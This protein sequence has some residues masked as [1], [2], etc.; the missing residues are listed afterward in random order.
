MP[1]DFFVTNLVLFGVITAAATFGQSYLKQKRGGAGAGNDAGGSPAPAAMTP[2]QSGSTR[3]L[4]RAYILVYALV[5]GADWLQGPYM[6][7]LYSTHYEFADRTVA[8]LFVF[9]FTAGGISAPY[10]GKWADKHGR[11]RMCLVFCATYGTSCLI[12]L[13]RSLPLLLLGR[14]LGGIST[15][16]LFSCFETWLISSAH[17]MSVPEAELSSI[18]SR[19]TFVNGLVATASGIFSNF[20]VEATG[21]VKSPFVASFVCLVLAGLAINQTWS[22]NYGEEKLAVAGSTSKDK[23]MNGG[24]ANDADPE[25]LHPLMLDGSSHGDGGARSASP[26]RRGSSSS[27]TMQAIK[28]IVADPSLLTLGITVTFYETAMYLFVFLWVPALQIVSLG[29]ENLPFGIIFSAYMICMSFG[30]LLY[31]LGSD[32]SKSGESM[33]RRHSTLAVVTCLVAA[34]ALVTSAISTTLAVRFWAFCVFEMTVGAYFPTL[35][36]LR[37]FLIPDES[38]GSF[39]A[40]FRV[41]LNVLVTISL[42]TGAEHH[43]DLVILA[44]VAMLGLASVAMVLGIRRRVA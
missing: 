38:R 33:V 30:S 4:W 8:A 37:G 25:A 44:S 28:T 42:L 21:S 17:S 40:L 35:G 29:G 32:T 1:Y 10:V 2:Q 3:S 19:C 34:A 7:P 27:G 18:L 22:E 41:P 26:A 15:S 24:G 20:L 14:V 6:Y 11:K 5:M 39:S 23:M 9:G 13:Y 12:V 43:K 16:I 36:T 31:S